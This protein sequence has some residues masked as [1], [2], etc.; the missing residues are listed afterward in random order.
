MNPYIEAKFPNC[1][2]AKYIR[3]QFKIY[4]DIF[5]TRERR[6][7]FAQSTPGFAAL[8]AVLLDRDAARR[9]TIAQVMQTPVMVGLYKLNPV[10]PYLERR[11]VSTLEP[12]K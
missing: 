11:L 10:D 3:V 2:I 4:K 7:Y 6:K 5:F 9:P 8:V 12:K 1:Q